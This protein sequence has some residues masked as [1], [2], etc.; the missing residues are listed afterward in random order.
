MVLKILSITNRFNQETLGIK[1][2]IHL[3]EY[4]TTELSQARDVTSF[5][6]ISSSIL[7]CCINFLKTLKRFLRS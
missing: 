1:L 3:F 4:S 6:E 7:T 5:K 2:P